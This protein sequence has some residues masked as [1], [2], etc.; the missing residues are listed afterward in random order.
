MKK[1]FFLFAF[2]LL[3]LAACNA[4]ESSNLLGNDN[5]NT[6]SGFGVSGLLFENNLVMWDREHQGARSELFPQMYFTRADAANFPTWNT[7]P[8]DKMASG[9]VPRDGI[10]A[11]TNP[12]FVAASSSEANYVRNTDLV[13]GAVINGEAR[14]YP[15]NI[16]WWHEIVNDEIGGQRVMMTFCPLTGTGLFF[17]A[18]DRS[19]NV[20]RLELLPVIETTWE[21][22]KELYPATTVISRNT[23]FNR[24]YT[25]YPYGNYRS[26][27]TPP[28]F[29]LRTRNYDTRFQPKHVVLGLIEGGVQKAYAFSKLNGKPVVN[30]QI[31]GRD[32]VIVSD[33]SAKLAIPYERNVN[34]QVL[35]FT[36]SSASPF[37]M[38]DNA[39]NSV[40]NI[41]GEAISGSL[42]GTKLKQIPAYNAFWFAWSVFWPSTQVFE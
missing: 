25:A 2:A 18:P 38:T 37:Q 14:A 22:W 3:L 33:L 36:L 13:L 40:W 15:E 23:G 5:G 6:N 7:F 19:A 42:A 35:N 34:G 4:D 21:K 41:K 9:G 27:A 39:T 28:L 32:V 1:T 29:S 20:D 8:S 26:E 30:D 24:D 16:L 31:N 11:L 12:K 17:R 10:P